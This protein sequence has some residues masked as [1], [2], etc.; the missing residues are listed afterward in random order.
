VSFRLVSDGYFDVYG[1]A[2]RRGRAFS[3]AEAAARAPVALVSESLARRLWPGADA[4]G[5]V[6]QLDFQTDPRRGD[7]PQPEGPV[8]IVGVAADVGPFRI[9]PAEAN[10][11]LTGSSLTPRTT[12]AARIDGD[13][14]AARRLVQ[15]RVVAVD[16]G[17]ALVVSTR[18]IQ[19]L[20]T[21]PIQVA[22]WATAILGGLAL[23]LTVSGIVGVVS[24]LVAQR[25]REIGIRATLGATRAATTRLVLQQSMR[26][27]I[28]GLAFGLLL[29]WAA[30]AI[31]LAVPGA[32][33][34]GRL[35]DVLDPVAYL[36]GIALVTA[37]CLGAAAVP[38]LRG[39]RVSPMDALRDE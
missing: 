33:P 14:E 9:M 4:V 11:Y 1:I 18:S 12:L 34:V 29:A 19:A 5:Q 26:P 3:E 24:F 30:A 31:V 27:A 39:T 7:P 17:V 15:Q 13:V 23:V 32:A 21:Y 10:L 22:F 6:L 25:A 36:L 2:V 37:V 20:E 28:G 38:T 16:P 35:V 8:T